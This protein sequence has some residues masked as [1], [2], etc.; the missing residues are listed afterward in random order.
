MNEIVGAIFPV[1]TELVN[2][3]FEGETKVF[4][5]YVAH[6][7]TRLSPGHKIVF[8]ASRGSKELIGEGIVEKVEFLTPD[9]VLS[10]FKNE[11]FLDAAE[12]HAYVGKW[13]SRTSKRI[14]TLVLKKLK[15]YQKPIIY[16][17]PMTMAG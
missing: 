5:K 1:P 3:L 10:K 9:E 6:S 13:P 12:F 4:V 8:Y 16:G 17:K 14:M 15:K 2:R 7:N 11:L